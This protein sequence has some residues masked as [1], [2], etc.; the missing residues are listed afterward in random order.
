MGKKIDSLLNGFSKLS[1]M[2]RYEKLVEVGALEA[3]DVNYLRAGGI[4]DMDLAEHCIENVIGYFQLPMGVATNFRMNDKDY[5]LP[6]AVE[7]TSIIAAL[8]K[9]AKWI[10]RDG[11]IKTRLIGNRIIGQIQFAKVSDPERLKNTVVANQNSLIKI[12]NQV[13]SGLVHRGGGVD[14]ISVRILDREVD[15]KSKMVVLHVLCDP[16]EAMGANLINQ[17]CE[18]L[19]PVL[20]EMTG[21]T[22]SMCIL[23][24]LVDTKLTEAVVRI[25]NID[26]ELGKGIEEASL[27]AELDPYR[28]ATNNKGVLNGMDPIAIATGNDWRAVEAGV[29]AYAA[30]SGQYKSIT[31]WYMEGPDLVGKFVAPVIVGTVGGVTKIHPTAQLGLKILNVESSAELSQVIAAAGLVQNLGAIRALST[32]GIVN[33]HM[34]LHAANLAIAAG[35]ESES[36]IQ[37][38]K[39]KLENLLSSSNRISLQNAKD[40]LDTYR[41]ERQEDATAKLP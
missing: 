17:A 22:V 40:A 41:V 20:E 25:K 33:G 26:R 36:E 37:H 18:A 13:L 1:R 19:K 29:H 31:R 23:S 7:E 15:S 27:F 28:A 39:T 2:E 21:E 10:R 8:S 5:L 35:A 6:M 9:N 3:S 24:N 32:V 38:V 16:C 34:K 30:R 14:E 12:A 11:E 4:A